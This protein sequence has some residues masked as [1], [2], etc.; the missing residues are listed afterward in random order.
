MR[1]FFNIS[2]CSDILTI[3][4]N[5]GRSTR[6]SNELIDRS[7]RRLFEWETTRNP[8]RT[9]TR[10][11]EKR[12]RFTVSICACVGVYATRAYRSNAFFFP[13]RCMKAA[14]DMLLSMGWF[15]KSRLGPANATPSTTL[16]LAALRAPLRHSVS[17]IRHRDLT[18]TSE[19]IHDET[20]GCDRNA[21][22][23]N[24]RYK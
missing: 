7:R 5:E 19:R 12:G 21:A 1:D 10:N 6:H 24:D 17:L 23:N 11:G 20:G 3:V 13:Y 8:N 15:H 16:S 2:T 14:V 18:A 9:T 4:R 22:G